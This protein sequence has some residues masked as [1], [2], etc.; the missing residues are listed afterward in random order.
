MT[1]YQNLSDLQS[2]LLDAFAKGITTVCSTAESNELGPSV[3]P[4]GWPNCTTSI[5]ACNRHFAPNEYT[6]QSA[7][8]FLPAERV[9]VDSLSY[10]G[11]DETVSGS[12]VATAMA[13]GLAS[14][15]LSCRNWARKANGYP[16]SAGVQRRE[17][18]ERVFDA[19]MKP[20]S[21]KSLYPTK[22]FDE[23]DAL[24]HYASIL[25][26]KESK[27]EKVDENIWR[28]WVRK[29]FGPSMIYDIEEGGKDTGTGAPSHE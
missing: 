12:S 3:Y 5:S 27:P 13:A 24:K 23:K 16:R 15:T 10:L 21:G 22:V 2:M 18:I 25:D 29:R 17:V 4:A 1:F 11:G 28:E 20:H 14:L 26:S 7:K 19:M 9:S 6:D 8:Y